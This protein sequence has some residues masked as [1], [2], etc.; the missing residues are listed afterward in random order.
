MKGFLSLGSNLG[1]R[2]LNLQRA[3]DSL[4]A[5][6]VRIIDQS[7]VYETKALE[8]IHPQRAYFNMVL[9]I[10]TIL[11]PFELLQICHQIEDALGRKRPYYHA[12]RSIDVDILALE[13]ITITTAELQVPHPRMESRSF[14]MYPLSEIASDMILPSGRHIQDVKKALGDDEIVLVWKKQGWER[15]L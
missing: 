15:T 8:V 2:L 6:N 9:K 1:D 12:P 3:R 7:S 4:P 10:E 14:V 13:G 11:N 5:Y